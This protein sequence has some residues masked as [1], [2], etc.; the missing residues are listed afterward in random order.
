M[1]TN[2]RRIRRSAYAA[3]LIAAAF[4]AAP[5]FAAEEK[6]PTVSAAMQKPLVEIQELLKAGKFPEAVEKLK[7]ADAMSGK[8]PYDQFVINQDMA[9]ACQKTNDTPCLTKALAG[10]SGD[11]YTPPEDAQRYT[12][13]VAGLNYQAK[14]YDQAIEYGNRAI[15][16]GFASDE[17][18]LLVASAYYIKGDYPAAAKVAEPHIADTIKAGKKPNGD[19][20]NV[21]MSACAKTNDQAGLLRAL[22]Y[23]VTYYPKTETWYDL[24]AMIRQK[25]S[26][27]IETM[28]TYRLMLTV[29]SMKGPEDYIEMADIAMR[30][31]DPGEARSALQAGTEKGVF[32]GNTQDRSQH[33]IQDAKKA[34]AADE[35]TLAKAEPDADAASTGV[36][37][38]AVGLGYLGY[39]QYD[40]AVAQL[41]K[42]V[43]KGGLKND[44]DTR[45]LLG[46]AELKAGH[47]DDAL[48]TFATVKGS[49]VLERLA[50]LWT[51]YAR[52]S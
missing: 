15:K 52:Q 24:L 3:A 23:Q 13:A 47:K 25:A 42:A 16:G 17:T 9:M 32:S 50:A 44:A 28:Q 37:N 41:S 43:S 40:K 22:E 51:I 49:P 4:A 19:E 7:T 14:Q 20:L 1:T 38:A 11:A 12:R 46:I 21:Y 29:G 5:G 8:S 2:H 36:K 34:A 18:Y 48:K 26:G 39:Q 30:L 27:D 31:G 35:P 6:K 33:M 45:L 10:L